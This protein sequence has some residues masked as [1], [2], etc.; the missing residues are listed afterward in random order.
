MLFSYSVPGFFENGIVSAVG[1]FLKMSLGAELM[2]VFFSPVS[3]NM[4]VHT[5]VEDT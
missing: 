1:C 2:H 4:W 5:D 3:L